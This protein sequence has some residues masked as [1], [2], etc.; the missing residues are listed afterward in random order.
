VTT[1]HGRGDPPQGWRSHGEKVEGSE[2]I[3]LAALGPDTPALGER[4]ETG[5]VTQAQVAATLAALLGEDYNA[6]APRAAP[7]IADLVKPAGG[8]PAAAPAR[9]LSRIAF[10][11][12]ASEARP[13]P[14]WA[15]IAATKPELLLMLGDNIYADTRDMDVMRAKYARLAAMPGFKA[16][17]ESVPILATWDDHDLGV[18]DGGSDYPKKVESQRIFLDFFG[19]P[20]DSPRRK[21]PGVYDARVFGPEGRRVQVIMLDTRYFRSSPLRRSP[22]WPGAKGRTSRTPT[23]RRPCSGRTSGAGWRSSSA[24]RPRCG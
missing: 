7:P 17:R 21:R 13:Q 3:W 14:I 24:R 16:L 11:S 12:C 1:D 19:D 6:E 5:P 20:E 2:A 9:P 15:A 23:R 10:G 18:D 8:G 4:S 22:P